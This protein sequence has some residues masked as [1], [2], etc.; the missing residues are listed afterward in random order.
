LISRKNIYPLHYGK[1]YK[2]HSFRIVKL[3]ITTHELKIHY[4]KE[5]LI[6]RQNE[7]SSGITKISLKNRNEKPRDGSRAVTVITKIIMLV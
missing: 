3:V 7:S 2:I 5:G 1:A 6:T 4:L